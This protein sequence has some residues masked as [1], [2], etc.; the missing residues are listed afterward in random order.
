[1]IYY[2]HLVSTACQYIVAWTRL[3]SQGRSQDPFYAFS[4]EK[5]IQSSEFG[6]EEDEL[7]QRA[8]LS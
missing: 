4:V 1:M 5:A 2:V 8:C 6:I 7:H 3:E